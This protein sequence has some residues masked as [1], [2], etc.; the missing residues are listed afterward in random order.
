MITESAEGEENSKLKI[1][2][3]KGN[4]LLLDM[5]DTN[6]TLITSD[7]KKINIGDM[8]IY[9]KA[10]QGEQAVSEPIP[11][12]FGTRDRPGEKSNYWKNGRGCR[13]SAADL[14]INGRNSSIR[15]G[16]EHLHNILHLNRNILLS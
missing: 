10:L 6:G 13:H 15:R 2:K 12:S 4:Y 5:A 11:D 3:V 1:W 16:N 8:V 9:Q 14:C 7:N